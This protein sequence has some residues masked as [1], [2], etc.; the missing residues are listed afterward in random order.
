MYNF[1]MFACIGVALRKESVDRNLWWGVR[2]AVGSLVAL[3][4]ESVDRNQGVHYDNYNL[5]WSLSARRAWIEIGNSCTQAEPKKVALRK[6]SVDRN[7]ALGWRLTGYLM[8]LSA[9]RAWIEI[10]DWLNAGSLSRGRSPQGE[11]G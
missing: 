6:E 2:K 11:R 7:P 9:R 1:R 8:S 4:K 3:R 5:H 10:E